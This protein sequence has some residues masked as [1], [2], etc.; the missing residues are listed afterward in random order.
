MGAPAGPAGS[1][2]IEVRP[3]T[4]GDDRAVLALLGTSLGWVPDEQHAAFFAWKH[5]QNPA[6][7]SPAWVA[8]HG[9][10]VVGYRTFVRWEFAQAGRAVAVVRAVDTATHPDYRGRG[11]FSRLTRH[12]LASLHEEG[13]AFVFNTPNQRSRPGYLKM[14][15]Q[16]VARL[17]VGLRP[18]SLAAPWRWLRSRVPAEKWSSPPTVGLAVGEVV[19]D[20]GAER[21]LESQ[22]LVPGL[23]THR[24][25]AFLEWRYG[26]GPLGYRALL[27]A[28][29]P[30]E[31]FAIVRLKRRGAA[32][33][34]AV[35]EALV[36][37]ADPHRRVRLLRRLATRVGADH[38]LDLA[39]PAAWRAGFVP[40]PGQG[41]ALV[42]RGLTAEAVP[43]RDQW[44]LTLGDVELF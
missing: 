7:A 29:E 8:L 32:V 2:E 22:P 10:R 19:G 23:A 20:P 1:A 31:G 16:P 35:C 38:L 6:G 11:I 44:H 42:Y 34:G 41:P 4:G 5:R 28:D 18:C 30:E 26:F 21:L 43:P 36:P 12:A 40:L 24:H 13:V 33:E 15:W 25:K 37:G 27:L 39:H 3:A 17:A 14:G 9:E